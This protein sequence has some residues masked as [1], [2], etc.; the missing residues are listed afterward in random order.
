[1][2]TEPAV[3]DIAAAT[4]CACCDTDF[5][6]TVKS[7]PTAEFKSGHGANWKDALQQLYADTSRTLTETKP[8]F[9]RCPTCTELY[10]GIPFDQWLH[11]SK[12][13]VLVLGT[14]RSFGDPLIPLYSVESGGKGWVKCWSQG[15]EAPNK[16]ERDHPVSDRT[17]LGSYDPYQRNY[18]PQ[19]Y[20]Y[21]V[22]SIRRSVQVAPDSESLIR[23]L[24]SKK[25]IFANWDSIRER[26]EK[27]T[28]DHSLKELRRDDEERE[29]LERYH[30]K[31]HELDGKGES[32]ENLHFQTILPSG[33]GGERS[34]Q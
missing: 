23:E 26:V 24:L 4:N 22:E 17:R 32:G 15:E 34:V 6:F 18:S 20:E 30:T 9:H 10:Y 1:M 33:T 25:P 21:I 13:S 27:L 5:L 16:L 11:S 12:P 29:H 3:I 2:E 28:G 14:Y 7:I 8:S 31:S 19:A